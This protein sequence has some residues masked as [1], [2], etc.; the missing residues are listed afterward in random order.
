MARI[1]VGCTDPYFKL[2]LVS[3]LD[4]G[5][6]YAIAHIRGGAEWGRAWYE[7]DGK[8]LRKKNTFYDFILAAET[9]FKEGYTRKELLAIEGR[10]A[11]G[12]LIGATI[13]LR[14]DLAK[15]ALAGVPF[16]DVINT[17]MDESIPLTV[18]E[19]EE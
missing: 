16:V 5:F 19:Y 11:G 10:S 9:L 8:F 7:E 1:H 13:N 14:P 15:V 3:L 2:S 18:N 6:V 4:R 12:L 17:M